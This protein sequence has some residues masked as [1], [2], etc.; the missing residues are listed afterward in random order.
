MLA[1]SDG[2]W[3]NFSEA[4]FIGYG[5]NQRMGYIVEFGDSPADNAITYV[6]VTRTVTF[7]INP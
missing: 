6:P 4:G 5:M 3:N 1:G 7:N 2:L